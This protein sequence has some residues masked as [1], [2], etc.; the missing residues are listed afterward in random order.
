MQDTFKNELATFSDGYEVGKKTL[1]E[2]AT[3]EKIT[4]DALGTEMT[5]KCPKLWDTMIGLAGDEVAALEE[6]KALEKKENEA[7]AN[8]AQASTGEEQDDEP[9]KPHPYFVRI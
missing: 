7:Q 4:S 2:K 8:G 1:I 9:I 3:M 5:Q 6:E